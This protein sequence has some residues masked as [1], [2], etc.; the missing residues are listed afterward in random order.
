M[1]KNALRQRRQRWK[2]WPDHWDTKQVTILGI[3]QLILAFLIL[4]MEIGN[5]IVDLYR[6]NVYSGFWSFPFLL[7]AVIATFASGKK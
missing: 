2:D 4:G 1:N 6:A 7:A 5:S 3:I